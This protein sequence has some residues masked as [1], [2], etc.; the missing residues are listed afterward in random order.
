MIQEIRLKSALYL[1]KES[2]LRPL[3]SQVRGAIWVMELELIPI[4]EALQTH[5]GSSE[6]DSVTCCVNLKNVDK[7]NILKICL[8]T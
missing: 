2:K 1:F 6:S 7:K 8:I 3:S 4:P 5:Y